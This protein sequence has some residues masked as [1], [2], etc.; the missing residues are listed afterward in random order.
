M[1]L[2]LL[3]LIINSFVLVAWGKY[4]H[5]LDAF[6]VDK[7]NEYRLATLI[8]MG[9][10]PS[11]VIT[12]FFNQFW[13]TAVYNLTGHYKGD[14]TFISHFLLTGLLEEFSKFLIFIIL[15]RFY[16]SIKEPRDG[17]LQAASIAMGFALT[18][19]IIYSLQY[20]I[21]VLLL[22]SIITIIGH[23][24]YAVI[25]GYAW[26]SVGYINGGKTKTIGLLYTLIALIAAAMFHGA[27]NFFL[28]SLLLWFALLLDVLAIALFFIIYQAV[29]VNSPYRSFSLQEYRTAIPTLQTGL[30]KYPDSYVLNKK[31]GI[32]YIYA[33]KYRVAEKY[34]L[35]A[36][37]LRFNNAESKFYCGVSIYLDGK[38]SD[39]IRVMN[40]ALTAIP[41]DRIL[42]IVSSL[43]K[44]ISS[45]AEREELLSRFNK[46]RLQFVNDAPLLYKRR[47]RSQIAKGHTSTPR[48]LN[49]RSSVYK[50]DTKTNLDA[51]K[52]FLNKTTKEKNRF[53]RK[54]KKRKRKVEPFDNRGNW[55]K[56]F[57]EN[58]D[59]IIL[60]PYY[61][62]KG[63]SVVRNQDKMN[64][65]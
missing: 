44:V 2:F 48:L 47:S 60:K 19:N 33:Q 11:V 27:S 28:S 29:K 61:L 15:T 32:F 51:N 59:P 7:K 4:L 9:G 40:R 18:E 57:K 24:S 65:K 46:N 41:E 34:L 63:E 17:M 20:G 53:G 56:L 37:K 6:T 26:G 16:K 42:R 62:K 13:G 58:P 36:R 3:T 23:V 21:Y 39:G 31:L 64:R 25:W 50:R 14:N 12:L 30:Q 1:V 54:I 49:R 55:E 45:E 8:I 22:R 35:K 38:T 43:K 10:V 5:R 52:P